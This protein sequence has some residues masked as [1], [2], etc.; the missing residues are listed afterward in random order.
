MYE[1]S[2]KTEG[3][4]IESAAKALELD[5]SQFD[6]EI[7]ESERGWFGRSHVRIRVYP[8]G[9][10]Q[11][12]RHNDKG[13]GR[14]EE[15]EG[16]EL[17]EWQEVE[18]PKA[19]EAQI[20][21]FMQ[22]LLRR[23][24]QDGKVLLYSRPGERLLLKIEDANDASQLIGKHGK[25]LDA[26]QILLNAYLG[27]LH[28]EKDQIPRSL[29]VQLDVGSY[30]KEREAKLIEIARE[31]ASRVERRKNSYLLT[32][33]NPFERRIVH[34]ALNDW[35]GISTASEGDGQYKQVRIIYCGN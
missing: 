28:D 24:G 27:R 19:Y 6:V 35:P 29:R 3:E 22:E 8:H 16:E 4:A 25:H 9:A 33:M 17:P 5:S 11:Q 1:F 30:R 18:E 10:E 15:S 13:E 31:A 2:G 21:G 14:A 12:E 23:M 20:Q 7:L 26:L 34:K 32:A